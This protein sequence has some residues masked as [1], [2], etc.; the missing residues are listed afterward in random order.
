MKT[1][2]STFLRLR[3]LLRHPHLE[4]ELDAELSS[5][6]QLHIDDNLRAGMTPAEARRQALLRLGGLEQ[7]KERFRAQ[8]TLPSLESLFHDLRYAARLLRKTPAFT[9]VVILSLSLGIG[10]TTAIFHLI[11]A[12]R[13]RRLPVS[14]PEDLVSVQVQGGNHG[15]GVNAGP[16]TSLTY[17]LWQQIRERQRSFSGVFAWEPWGFEFGQGA[18]GKSV[19]GLW[20]SGELFATLGIVPFRG[21]LIGPEDDR[22]GCGYRGVVIS[23]AFWQ[24]QFAGQDS[25]IGQ[26]ILIE[27][28]PVQVLGVTPPSFHGLEV[29]RTF[30][31]AVPFCSAAGPNPAESNLVRRDFFWLTVMGRLKPDISLA[32]AA[33]E[34]AALSPG[35]IEATTP[36][37]YS[38]HALDTYR[39]Y[40]LTAVPAAHGFS[41]LR[42]IYATSLW[43][44]LGITALVLLMVCV[45]IANLVLARGSIRQREMALRLALGASRWRLARQLLAES[46]LLA[47]SGAVLGVAL[48]SF[49]SR[50]LL[51]LI[52]AEGD[53]LQLDLSLDWRVLAFVA[54]IATLTS[55]VFGLAPALRFSRN[56]PGDALKS[57]GRGHTGNRDSHSFQRL[58][59]TSQ[60]ACSFVLLVGALL[61]VH[62]FYNLSKVDPGFRQDGVVMVFFDFEKLNL[63]PQRFEAEARD[64][65]A[66]VRSI[67]LVDSAATSTH[68]PF[69]GSWTS[70]VTVDSIEGPSKFTWVSPGYLRT[71]R[72]PLVAGRDFNDRDTATAPHVAIVSQTF[73]S[74]FLAGRDPIGKIIRTAPEPRYP[75]GTY[76]IVGV[77]KDTKY[78]DLREVAPPPE[79]Y[80][81][82]SQFPA[83]GPEVM[84]LIHSLSPL[85]SV[86]AAVREKVA[87]ASPD[88]SMDF[89]VLK[90]FVEDSL[91][92]ER[93]LALL[94]GSFGFLAVLLAMIGLYGVVSYMITLRRVEIGIRMALGASRQDIFA[95]VLRQTL[96]V[97]TV[98]IVAGTL[99]ALLAAHGAGSLL[100]GI[101]SNDPFTL[102][103]AAAFL[104]VVALIAS[105]VPAR[106]ATRVDPMI[107]LRYE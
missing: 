1:I 24:S 27:D 94:S 73:V 47:A 92:R 39:G 88:V 95:I 29:G 86:T 13:L 87:A 45:N 53:R 14:H 102:I 32:Q 21:R 106:G 71:M 30:D 44:L 46:L 9:A 90:R 34:L 91:I 78:A 12:V 97:L 38:N 43:L 60:V 83:L 65:L 36:S 107:A 52:T 68:L 49:L 15:F 67:P 54:A 98:G 11:D 59:V 72:V 84:V 56:T 6:L 16:E 18:N 63:P 105:F 19:A 81:P 74:R 57:G 8:R 48:A 75:A 7:T 35:I 82:A 41:R 28:Y 70:G 93:M 61:F 37:G 79:A 22:R 10:A 58:L 3:N 64:L 69:D 89:T 99:L 26:K 101:Q 51:R 5:H 33:A 25:A 40:V 23:Y 50:T 80:A 85:P 4:R 62:S 42:Q 17:P 55:V 31:V 76:E 20:V 2:R 100:F 104:S 77:V 96:L 103:G 66:Q